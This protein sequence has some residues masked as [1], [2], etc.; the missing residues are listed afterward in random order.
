MKLLKNKAFIALVS[1]AIA[2]S[3][4]PSVLYITGGRDLLREGLSLAAVPFR[5]A[6]NWCADGIAG[7]SRYFTSVDELLKENEELRAEL[8][9]LQSA[10]AAGEIKEYENEWLR[11]QL[12]FVSDNETCTFEDASVIGFSASG[13]SMIYTVDRGS[14]AGLEKNMA[15]ISRGGVVGYISEVGLGTSK[16][17]A[18]T[19]ISSA[20]GVYCPRSGVYGT[21]RGGEAYISDGR[22][23]I[24]GL[25][26]E[27]DVEVGDL[28]CTSGYG[29]I[30]PK[31]IAVGRV[32]AVER[33]EFLRNLTVVL[34]PAAK[35]ETVGRVFIVTS[36][37]VGEAVEK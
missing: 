23:M 14:E 5:A 1:I 29:G 13:Y 18:L 27:S 15:V 12:G 10:A 36:I 34:E 2:L 33:D 19:D 24:A 28:F 30:F 3:V 11:E 21:A 20:V 25:P 6:V 8:D 37:E 32:I 31:D 17:C 22:F 9:R 26:V 4:I 35:T 16:V 7:F